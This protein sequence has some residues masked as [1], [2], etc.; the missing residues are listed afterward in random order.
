MGFFENKDV[1]RLNNWKAL[2]H[3]HSFKISNE[4]IDLITPFLMK[5]I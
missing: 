4:V 2:F 1:K 3:T 5:M